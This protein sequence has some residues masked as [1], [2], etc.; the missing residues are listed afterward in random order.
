MNRLNNIKS[1]LQKIKIYSKTLIADFFLWFKRY[2]KCIDKKINKIV[3]I[4]F[5][6]VIVLIIAIVII[7]YS[8]S[9]TSG[10]QK[11]YYAEQQAMVMQQ[12]SIAIDATQRLAILNK[13]ES[14][15]QKLQSQSDQTKKINQNHRALEGLA[16]QLGTLI[17][18]E[19]HA[20]ERDQDKVKTIQKAQTKIAKQ[21]IAMSIMDP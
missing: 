19:R 14:Q 13:I 15:L 7:A 5:I 21:N 6:I 12:K 17:Q 2:T 16:V 20:N 11:L 18:T 1:Y 3:A 8:V 4:N 9:P 10:K